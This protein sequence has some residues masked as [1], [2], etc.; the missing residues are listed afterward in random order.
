MIPLLGYAFPMWLA[1]YN[2][3]CCFFFFL[4]LWPGDHKQHH[5]PQHDLHQN[6]PEVWAVGRQQSQHRVRAGLPLRAA[7]DKGN[8]AAKALCFLEMQ[9]GTSREVTGLTAG[10]QRQF[11]SWKCSLAHLQPVCTAGP[12]QRCRWNCQNYHPWNSR[13]TTSEITRI[14]IPGWYFFWY[15]TRINHLWNYQNYHLWNYQNYHPWNYH[16]LWVAASAAAGN[17]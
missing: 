1:C 14:T 2:S 3:F 6:I 9:P 5:H 15:N 11:A 17:E 12:A 7:A 8:R 4:C 10:L 13:I 16:C